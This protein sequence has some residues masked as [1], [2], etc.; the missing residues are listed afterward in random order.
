[1]NPGRI[2]RDACSRA[3]DCV[4]TAKSI[5]TSRISITTSTSLAKMICWSAIN[6]VL[7]TAHYFGELRATDYHPLS[8][9]TTH[10]DAL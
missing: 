9:S 2:E 5:R 8:S 6:R 7:H 4:R 10:A 3:C 1:M